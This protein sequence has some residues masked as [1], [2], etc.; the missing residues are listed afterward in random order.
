MNQYG[1]KSF[2]HWKYQEGNTVGKALTT[3]I[4]AVGTEGTASTGYAWMM[5]DGR[6]YGRITA[7]SS[8]ATLYITA[9]YKLRVLDF[10]ALC[11]VSHD[12]GA[13]SLQRGANVIKEIFCETADAITRAT[14]LDVTYTVISAA[15]IIR[16][17]A[18]SDSCTGHFIIDTLPV[19]DATE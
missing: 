13:L 8:S 3:S 4:S 10:W 2:D 16:V 14:T 9:P 7:T 15:S 6:I 17:K 5:P 11:K 1:K 18:I 19:P 12:D